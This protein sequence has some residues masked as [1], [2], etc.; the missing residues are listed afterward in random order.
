MQSLLGVCAGL[1]ARI[2]RRCGDQASVNPK[3][4]TV[5]ELQSR[6]KNLHMGMCKLLKE[7][8]SL[9]AEAI[10]ADG[11]APPDL[12]CGIRERITKDFD[13]QTHRHEQVCVDAFND[14]AQYKRLMNEAIDGKAHALEKMCMYLESAAASMSESELEAIFNAPLA[15][16]ANQ[17]TVM[18]LRTGITNFPWA[19]VV[20]ERSA[21]IDLGEWDAASVSAQAREHV[22]SALRG[23]P[24]VRFVRAKGVKL[25]LSDG[26]AT[27]ELKWGNNAAVKALPVTVSLLLR[28]C[29]RLSTLDVRCTVA[30][31]PSQHHLKLIAMH[32]R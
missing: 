15:D 28:N 24:N 16:F 29:S 23:N 18:Q 3:A 7:D 8:L 20:T 31:I 4:E 2:L 14:D 19:A 12:M 6:R 27:T 32:W 25:A 10:L 9:Q 21:D 26:W 1:F 13:A 11:S 17:A 22:A 5:E 30:R